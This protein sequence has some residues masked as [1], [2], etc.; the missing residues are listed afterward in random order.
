MIVM[1]VSKSTE[2]A[3]GA[4]V[5]EDGNLGEDP[6]LGLYAP[7]EYPDEVRST[8]PEDT[9]L[10]AEVRAA[11][12]LLDGLDAKRVRVGLVTF[13]GE[14]G[15]DGRQ[16]SPDQRDATLQVP[17]TQD[18]EQVRR[19]LRRVLARGPNGATNFAA[20]IRL[21][22]QELAGLSGASSKRAPGAKPVVLFLTD[23]RP[24]FPAGL[25]SVEDPGDL[26]AA[27]AAA[28]VAQSAGIRINTYAVGNDALAQPKAATEVARVTLGTYTPVLEP[29]AI[30]A[31]LQATSFA[32][33]EDIGVV[34][35]TTQE[36]AP[37]VRLNP[38]GS[39]QAFVPVREGRNRVL[40]NALAS[41]GTRGEH[42]DRVRLQGGGE[43]G[44][45]RTAEL[46]ADP[47]A[48][49]RADPPPRGR[50]D[51]ARAA[52]AAHQ[53]RARDPLGSGRARLRRAGGRREARW[54]TRSRPA[55]RPA[56]CTA[57]S[58]STT[59]TRRSPRRSTR[60]RPSGSRTRR[61]CAPTPRAGSCATSTG[62][63]ATPPGAPPSASS[64]ELEGAEATVLFA[65]GMAAATTTFLA[66]LGRGDHIVVTN[67]CYRRTRQFIQQLLA[68]LEVE[69]TVI[70][71]ADPIALKAALRDNTRLFF[72]E[73]PTNPYLRVIDVP[74]AVRVAHERG[75]AVIIDSTFAA[76]GE[77]P[78][79]RRRR[80]PRDP[81]RH[82]VSRRP[83]RPDR[84]H[85]V[86]LGTRR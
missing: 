16:K 21:A 30:A 56:P 43:E 9:I 72:T 5:D 66:L 46:R 31:A 59:T 34:N 62:A 48:E 41:D 70:E 39:F 18:Y 53:A 58:A 49:R 6:H 33:V 57:A 14:A 11:N 37:D 42:R 75:V 52:R 77:P 65:S 36:S 73:S 45:R 82:Q 47:Q 3:S 17:L 86:G 27:V 26:E 81:Q 35:L 19:A 2:A 54:P 85:R 1:D 4:D 63:T 7:G 20:G 15:P 55:T 71:P 78:R 44:A 13:S 64:R 23:G 29:G 40:V 76:P 22:T 28:R 25:A 69:A 68:K 80:R 60:P 84:R 10:H 79:A 74:E 38:D 83:Q 24:S 50:E 67:D 12:T 8:D 51:Q 32:N 61:S